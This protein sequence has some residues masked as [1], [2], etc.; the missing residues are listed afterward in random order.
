MQNK[1]VSRATGFYGFMG[2]GVQGRQPNMEEKQVA[3][4]MEHESETAL[5]Q[6]EWVL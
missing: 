6:A 4:S 1:R 5:K 3:K 2:F